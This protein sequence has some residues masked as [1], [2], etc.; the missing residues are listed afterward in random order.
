MGRLK[1]DGETERLPLF[2]RVLDKAD[3]QIPSYLCRMLSFLRSKESFIEELGLAIDTVPS[4]KELRPNL[5]ITKL[6]PAYLL[7]CNG[8]VILPNISCQVPCLLEL[9]RI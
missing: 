9:A 8:E 2:H 5:L 1:A 7:L 3:S 4:I 6:C